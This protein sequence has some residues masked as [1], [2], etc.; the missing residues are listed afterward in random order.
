MLYVVVE[1]EGEKY[2][3][4]ELGVNGRIILRCGI[5]VVLLLFGLYFSCT[6]TSLH[7]TVQ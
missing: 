5:P 2:H 3:V 6:L 4:E 7:N 1:I